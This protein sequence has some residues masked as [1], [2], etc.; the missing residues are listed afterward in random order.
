M[1]RYGIAAE[2]IR[3]V[4]A[5][6]QHRCEHCQS[7]E[8]YCP[9]PFSIEH[10]HPQALG[11]THD[12]DNLALSC[13]GCNGFKGARIVAFDAV[14]EREVALFHPGRDVWIEHFGWSEDRLTLRGLTPTGRVT[15]ELLRLNRLGVRNLRAGLLAMER[16]P[17]QNDIR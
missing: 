13:Q 3:L 8:D 7:P 9:D 17:A 11:G 2:I 14:S 5:R 6:A 12:A 15:I 1:S 16:H 10:I 4:F